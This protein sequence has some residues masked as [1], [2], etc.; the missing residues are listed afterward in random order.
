M[1][2]QDGSSRRIAWIR[3]GAFLFSC[4]YCLL[5]DVSTCTG[6]IL[7]V[8]P[9]PPVISIATDNLISEARKLT[10][11]T[12]PPEL[13]FELV[14]QQ[15]KRIV[16]SN[17]ASDSQPISF[18]SPG[19]FRA[20]LR[21]VQMRTGRS[22]EEMALEIVEAVAPNACPDLE[23]HPDSRDYILNHR[24]SLP[25]N[26]PDHLS[27]PP[28][29][30]TTPQPSP[31]TSVSARQSR[32]SPRLTPLPGGTRTA[33]LR[34]STTPKN[35]PTTISIEFTSPEPTPGKRKPG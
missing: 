9:V 23:E 20:W 17:R 3:A 10:I 33:A 13:E 16:D 30:T 32:P 15:I 31:A 19:A 1:L 14:K 24:L 2:I 35:S 25:A 34:K 5:A 18:A 27:L 28:I 6:Q 7:V 26:E 8:T 22:Y 29:A 11:K 21:S 12:G 4:A